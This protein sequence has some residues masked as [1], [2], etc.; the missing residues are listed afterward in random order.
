MVWVDVF[1]A[2]SLLP[3]FL[4]ADPARAACFYVRALREQPGAYCGR[5]DRILAVPVLCVDSSSGERAV[6]VVCPDALGA[7]V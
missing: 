2:A 4:A 3:V 5:A 7:C 6:N 1:A